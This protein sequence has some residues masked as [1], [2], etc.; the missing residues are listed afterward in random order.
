LTDTA[1][2]A[3]IVGPSLGAMGYRLVRVAMTGGH[4][5]TLQIMAERL[6]DA[7]M[8]VEDCA[9][10]S[11]SISAVLDV[12]DPIGGSYSLEISSPGIDR[13]LVQPEDYDRFVGHQ[14]RI[15]VAAAVDGR[16]RFSGRLLGRAQD[17]VRIS[18]ELG[19]VQLPIAE[20]V[21]A[22]LALS[23]QL[24]DAARKKAAP[25]NHSRPV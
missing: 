10:I 12:A 5:A 6:D 24:A 7:A 2:I 23:D 18:T 4:R 20:I 25:A 21:R 8:T 14:A 13:P 1:E 19:E 9:D 11:R 17:H 3:R 22:R 15:E 16:K